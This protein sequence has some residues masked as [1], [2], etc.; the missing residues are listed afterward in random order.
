MCG[1]TYSVAYRDS[2][3]TQSEHL[4]PRGMNGEHGQVLCW[5]VEPGAGAGAQTSG[6]PLRPADSVGPAVVALNECVSSRPAQN[7]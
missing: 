1:G 5:P 2:S 6:R 7:R 3:A 4:R